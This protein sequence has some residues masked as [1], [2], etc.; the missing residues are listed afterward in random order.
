[1]VIDTRERV[2]DARKVSPEEVIYDLEKK[3]RTQ[4]NL[5]PEDMRMVFASARSLAEIAIEQ[6]ESSFSLINW[7]PVIMAVVGAV[8]IGSGIWLAGRAA[9]RGD[10]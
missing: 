2:V 9:R 5:S 4:N 3:W 1:M 6:P 10:R 8:V 7:R